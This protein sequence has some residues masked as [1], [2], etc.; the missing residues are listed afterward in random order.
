M[1][2]SR[3]RLSVL[4]LSGL[5]LSCLLLGGFGCG[6]DNPEQPPTTGTVQGQVTELT[7]GEPVTDA[8]LILIDPVTIA[9]HAGP[10]HEGG[11]DLGGQ[12]VRAHVDQRALVGPADGAPGGG[13]DD[14]FGHEGSFVGPGASATKLAPNP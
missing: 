13:D 7:S 9:V 12:L 14:G 8:V 4:I 6:E 5:S 10:A 1:S 3:R 2:G 11:D